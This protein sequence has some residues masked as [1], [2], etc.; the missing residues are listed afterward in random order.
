[1]MTST[2]MTVRTVC[3]LALAG[4]FL[5]APVHAVTPPAVPSPATET[6]APAPA[7]TYVVAPGDTLDRVIQKT[8][9]ASPLKLELLRQALVQANPQAIAA[10][11]N[12]RLKTGTVLQ[13]PDQDALLRA[14]ALPVMQQAD[15]APP[16]AGGSAAGDN[17]RRWVRYP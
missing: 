9:G 17:R 3:A 6:N 12:P 8:M 7:R 5:G 16:Q 1:M 15:T 10:G 14:V 2:S 4:A 11:R 13:L